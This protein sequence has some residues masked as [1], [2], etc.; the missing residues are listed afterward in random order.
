MTYV[1]DVLISGSWIRL[2]YRPQEDN[3]APDAKDQLKRFKDSLYGF[4]GLKRY[5]CDS[6][7]R[8]FPIFIRGTSIDAYTVTST[9]GGG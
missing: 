3:V 4:E 2:L 7:G 5:T 8:K 1:I 9:V 6:D